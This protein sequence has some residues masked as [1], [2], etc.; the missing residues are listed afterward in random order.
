MQ[1]IIIQMKYSLNT[2]GSKRKKK[3]TT[4]KTYTRNKKAAIDSIPGK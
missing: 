4:R 1:G 2:H 3:E